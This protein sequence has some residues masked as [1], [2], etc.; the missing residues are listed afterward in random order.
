VSDPVWKELNK[1]CSGLA[2]TA[3]AIYPSDLE[4]RQEISEKKVHENPLEQPNIK[5]ET[6]R[7]AGDFSN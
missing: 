3:S 2:W 4:K 7:N 1:T 6:A 5:D